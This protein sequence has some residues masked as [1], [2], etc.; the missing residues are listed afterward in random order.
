MYICA[1][2]FVYIDFSPTVARAVLERALTEL[3]EDA[4]DPVLFIHFAKVRLK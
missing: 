4:N 3:G 1:N 2:I